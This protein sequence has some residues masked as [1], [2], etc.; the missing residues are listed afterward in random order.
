MNND[1]QKELAFAEYWDKRYKGDLKTDEEE[2]EEQYEWFKTFD[3]LRPFLVKHL[4]P[5]SEHPRVLQL[6]CGTSTLTGDMYN[7]GYHEQ[8]SIDF[9]PVAIEVMKDKYATQNLDWQVMD[10]RK[11]TF[12]DAYF[13]VAIDKG[14]LDAMLHGSLWDPEDDVK[15]NAQAYVDEV[16][17]VLKPGGRWLY[18]TYRQP[19]FLKPLLER[20]DKWD[21]QVETLE[22]APG[23][24]EYFGFV[25]TRKS[26]QLI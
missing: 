19:H 26:E 12:T 14:T 25:M 23:T 1:A 11:L 18:V 9:S 15:A 17:R 13:D 8:V 4:P 5:G 2:D 10:V 3:K 16:A 6:G 22:D 21:L 7:L 20:P 24:F